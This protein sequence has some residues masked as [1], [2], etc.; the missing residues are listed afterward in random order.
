MEFGRPIRLRHLD[1][2]IGSTQGAVRRALGQLQT[3]KYD[4]RGAAPRRLLAGVDL[5][6]LQDLNR[7]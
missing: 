3:I 7:L 5:T 6:L 2:I 1:G 4:D